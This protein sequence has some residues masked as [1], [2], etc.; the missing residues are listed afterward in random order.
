MMDHT[1]T[2]PHTRLSGAW[3]FARHFLE[4][5]VAM[6]VGGFLLN[7]LIFVAG[8]AVLG[9]ADPRETAPSLALLLSAFIYT[10]PMAAWM[11]FRG[12]TWRP[13][14]EM[15]GAVVALAL[16]LIG[17]AGVGVITESDLRSLA[18]GFC[19]PACVVM[20]PVMLFRLDLYT[21]SSL[22]ETKQVRQQPVGVG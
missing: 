10:A 1:M 13:I 3:M 16:L 22:A 6:C 21:G 14:L 17:L 20:L 8:P 5:C 7:V 9:Y 4:M 19:G 11:R 18:L 15:S 2:R 12:M